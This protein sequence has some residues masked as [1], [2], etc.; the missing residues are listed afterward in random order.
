MVYWRIFILPLF[1]FVRL[2]HS[3]LGF[4]GLSSILGAFLVSLRN[5]FLLASGLEVIVFLGRGHLILLLEEK[6]VGSSG[7]SSSDEGGG[8]EDPPAPDPNDVAQSADGVDDHWSEGS[9]RIDTAA[10]EGDEDEMG[11][12]DGPADGDGGCIAGRG[13]GVHS[14]VQDSE[15]Q[16]VGAHAFDEEG[17]CRRNARSDLI[18]AEAKGGT[19][20]TS[21][22]QSRGLANATD[23]TAIGHSVG[24]FIVAEGRKAGGAS[25]K[26]ESS[27]E[28]ATEL[29]QHV[30]KAGLDALKLEDHEAEGD[31]RV[32]V[33]P[34]Q[35]TD[36]IS[37]DGNGKTEGEGDTNEGTD[38]YVWLGREI[39]KS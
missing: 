24:A 10:G 30:Q 38:V 31:G 4:T 21:I 17:R 27:E 18:D 11:D 9:G 35:M 37:Q 7:K 32:D 13:L 28:G 14:S 2:R 20:S 39:Y 33:A 15:D 5:L 19:V 12:E 8:V 6:F 16:E 25:P 3:V 26:D 29:G 1:L 34:R 22:G 36:A 23:Y